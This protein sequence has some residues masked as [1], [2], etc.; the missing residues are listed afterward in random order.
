M[1]L[2][3][4]LPPWVKNV[5]C[6]PGPNWDESV[7]GNIHASGCCPTGHTMSV[8]LATIV[9]WASIV[10]NAIRLKNPSRMNG[11]SPLR[12]TVAVW[13]EGTD[14]MK[15][16]YCKAGDTQGGDVCR[17]D[18]TYRPDLHGL[19]DPQL[20]TRLI[21]IM[22]ADFMVFRDEL[23]LQLGE[24]V[25]ATTGAHAEAVVALEKHLQTELDMGIHILWNYF[26]THGFR[27]LLDGTDLQRADTHIVFDMV[28]DEESDD[29]ASLGMCDRTARIILRPSTPEGSSSSRSVTLGTSTTPVSPSDAE[30]LQWGPPTPDTN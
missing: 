13:N 9:M 6:F 15:T 25:F 8:T 28:A 1:V 18:L 17:Y 10:I 23:W 16:T 4:G 2:P 7:H 27:H 14:N 30:T 11:W 29:E 22:C 19:D 26:G 12:S 3:R 20:H 5:P 21:E 24:V